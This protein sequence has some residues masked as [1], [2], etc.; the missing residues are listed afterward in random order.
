MSL[1]KV[2]IGN[3]VAVRVLADAA[4]DSLKASVT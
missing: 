1:E 4:A 2:Q 3:A